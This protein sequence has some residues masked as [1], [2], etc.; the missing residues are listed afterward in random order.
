MRPFLGTTIL[1]MA[2]ALALAAHAAQPPSFDKLSDADRKVFAARFQK[3]IWPLLHRS[4]KDGCIGCHQT[5]IVSALKFSGDIE[6]DFRMLLRDGFFL[7]GDDG[8]L[9]S[10]IEAKEPKRKMPPGIRP[11][12]T[13]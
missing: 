6:K 7:K 5:K 3:D 8:S 4:G 9:L 10:R 12:W 11:P 13:D 1:T 2:A